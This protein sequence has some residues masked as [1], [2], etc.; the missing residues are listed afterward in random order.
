MVSLSVFCLHSVSMDRQMEADN[1]EFIQ[2]HDYNEEQLNQQRVHS[3]TSNKLSGIG[4]ALSKNQN[5]HSSGTSPSSPTTIKTQ[6]HSTHSNGPR[7]PVSARKRRRS[8]GITHGLASV[9]SA[10]YKGNDTRL[11]NDEDIQELTDRLNTMTAVG[12]SVHFTN[13]PNGLVLDMKQYNAEHLLP[14]DRSASASNFAFPITSN[15]NHS[16]V[17]I[18]QNGVSETNANLGN[19]VNSGYSGNHKLDTNQR[20]ERAQAA[21]HKMQ[22]KRKQVIC[23]KMKQMQNPQIEGSPPHHPPTGS[24]GVHPAVHSVDSQQMTMDQLSD[25]FHEEDGDEFEGLILMSNVVCSALRNCRK[26][27]A[28]LVALEI[29]G[30]FAEYLHDDIRLDRLV[31]YVRALIHDDKKKIHE[32]HSVVVAKAIQ[33]LS[34][35][36]SKVLHVPSKYTRLFPDYILET[37]KLLVDGRREEIIRIE[38]ARQLATLALTGKY[39]IDYRDKDR[40]LT[41]DAAD[42]LGNSVVSSSTVMDTPTAMSSTSKSNQST[43]RDDLYK[44]R[45]KVSQLIDPLFGEDQYPSVQRALLSHCTQL[46]EFLGAKFTESKLIPGLFTFFNRREWQLRVSFLDVVVGISFYIGKQS[47]HKVLLPCLEECLND[48][49]PAVVQRCLEAFTSLTE[50]NIFQSQLLLSRIQQIVP[51]VVHY[52]AWVRN[53][54]VNFLLTAAGV[55]GDVRAHCRM[56]PILEPYLQF[57]IVFITRETLT[58]SLKQPLTV[59]NFN[60]LYENR[61]RDN[62]M[63]IMRQKVPL[64]VKD[65]PL[66]DGVLSY[67][68]CVKFLDDSDRPHGAGG[69]TEK[70]DNNASNEQQHQMTQSGVPQKEMKPPRLWSVRVEPTVQTYVGNMA[71]LPQAVMLAN[72]QIQL[73]GDNGDDTEKAWDEL[74]DSVEAITSVGMLK[75]K[76]RPHAPRQTRT[77][78]GIRDDAK[79]REALELPP[80]R[81]GREQQDKLKFSQLSYGSFYKNHQ[82]P[83]QTLSVPDGW[84]PRG[85]VITQLTEHEDAVNVMRVSR[86]NL[87]VAT[88]SNDSTV[89]IWSCDKMHRCAS[90]KSEQTYNGQKG[91]IISLAI[92]DSSHTIAS[93]SRDGTIHIF[94]VEYHDS[95]QSHDNIAGLQSKFTLVPGEGGVVSMEHFNTFTESLL[96]FGTQAGNIHA[97]DMRRKNTSFVLPMEPAMGAITAMCIGPSIHSVI[98]GTA[99]GF[100]VVFDLR[101]EMPVQMWRHYDASP[102]V[103]LSVINS[104]SIIHQQRCP[105]LTHPAKGPLFLVSTERSN[106]ICAFDLTTGTCRVRFRN[107]ITKQHQ[108]PPS[109]AAAKNSREREQA[110]LGHSRRE[111]SNSL[112]GQTLTKKGLF[113]LFAAKSESNKSNKS[114]D[115]AS[116]SSSYKKASSASSSN[117]NRNAFAKSFA[118]STGNTQLGLKI[119]QLPSVYPAALGQC[120]ASRPFALPSFEASTVLTHRKQL[121][122]ERTY[123]AHHGPHPLAL[124]SGHNGGGG[125]SAPPM[126]SALS[127]DSFNAISLES[128]V[129]GDAMAMDMYRSKM[130]KRSKTVSSMDLQESSSFL[131]SGGGGG[132]SA[133]NITGGGG[134]GVGGGFKS[135]DKNRMKFSA[136]SRHH[137]AHHGHHGHA[138]SS[139]AK[140]ERGFVYNCGFMPTVLNRAL[141]VNVIGDELEQLCSSFGHEHGG[142]TGV[143]IAKDQFLISAGRDRVVRYW[144]MQCPAKSFR[145]SNTSPNTTFTYNAYRDKKYNEVVFEELIEFEEEDYADLNEKQD[146]GTIS[147][148]KKATGK[149]HD[150]KA[151]HQDIITDL[152]AVEFPQ[153]M[154]LTASRNGIVKVWI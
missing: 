112:D 60:L 3:N 7:S 71:Q 85:R 31:P 89:K 93:G 51:L 84:K 13:T 118:G 39:F 15:S 28:R 34:S 127:G 147:S 86:D 49:R 21:R 106:E 47:L 29:I 27:S 44:L 73:A 24:N 128:K 37:L 35:I 40:L 69:T 56:L 45:V 120:P 78:K 87:F 36:L 139:S 100:I 1:D 65:Q 5:H 77:S 82:P 124:G 140:K 16:N 72:P 103:S 9:V 43:V 105:E 38:I 12:K 135:A 18:G 108:Y 143:L 119:S 152:K 59:S 19:L 94:R 33:V 46:C 137:S 129:G 8:S 122:S 6:S 102:I 126:R 55:L 64:L 66:Y 110:K 10:A 62:L 151:V 111:K 4:L 153:K 104:K 117:R 149:S 83:Y 136:S 67:I 41:L 114:A 125:S 75:N 115:G 23:A 123:S 132:G 92:L 42:S 154:L 148:S 88:A 57:P 80:Q 109:S 96:V 90:I 97:W 116:S 107:S 14:D 146:T 25:I 22:E 17:Q 150:S 63:E 20:A 81:S 134:G 98:V 58:A 131:P 74:K 32:E 61:E 30:G 95:G 144:D 26:A 101:F 121:F 48:A 79:I 91:E 50:M 138:H 2:L 113:G 99:R 54:C 11:L 142:S 76:G 68:R 133:G 141:N 52:S 130:S 53:S 145:I 70:Q